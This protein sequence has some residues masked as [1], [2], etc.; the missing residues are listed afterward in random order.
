MINKEKQEGQSLIEVVAALGVVA[1]GLFALV[2]VTT[3]SLR[4]A[5][6]AKN[7]ALATKYSQLTMEK[8]RENRDRNGWS[9][10]KIESNCESLAGVPDLP[11]PLLQPTINCICGVDSCTVDVVVSWTDSQGTHSSKSSTILTQWK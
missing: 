4:N 7:R 9:S 5:N 2:R 11:V 1:I 10:F 8:I 3:A 6:F